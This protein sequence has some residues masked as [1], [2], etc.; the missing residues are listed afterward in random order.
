MVLDRNPENHFAEVDQ[1]G[2]APARLV[3]GI[4][5]SPD[6]MLMGRIFSYHDT[7]LHRIGPNY[8][9]LPIN[10]P[11][12]PV[13]SYSR[14]GAMTYRHPGS[15]PVYSP[16]SYG[17]PEADPSKEL[18]TWWVEAGELGRYAYEKHADDDDF[19]QPRALY[20]DVMNDEDR[21]HLVTNIVAHA[22]DGVS[23]DV[24]RRVVAYWANVDAGLGA[25]VAEG[26]GMGGRSLGEAA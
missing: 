18:P 22:S 13:H 11:K 2:F 10:A 7:H 12:C 15:Q 3:P 25:R 8:E 16:N 9:Q 6:K 23:E 21:A 24:Q 4:G 14:D 5:L 26:L 20:R 19:V 1:A 17:G